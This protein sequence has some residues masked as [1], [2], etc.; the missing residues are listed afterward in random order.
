MTELQ[1]ITR[2]LEEEAG[3]LSIEQGGQPAD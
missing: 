2:T 1:N 3:G